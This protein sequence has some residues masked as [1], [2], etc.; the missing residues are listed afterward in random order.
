MH[1]TLND[2]SETKYSDPNLNCFE[3]VKIKIH[4]NSERQNLTFGDFQASKLDFQTIHSF[5]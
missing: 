4:A 2:D 5:V 1:Q 3:I